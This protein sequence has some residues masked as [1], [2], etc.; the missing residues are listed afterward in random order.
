MAFDKLLRGGRGGRRF[1]ESGGGIAIHMRFAARCG[2][3][4]VFL[5]SGVFRPGFLGVLGFA[6][7]TIAAN[8]GFELGVGDFLAVETAQPDGYV[9]VD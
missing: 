4:G 2:M 9:F 6:R 3:R 5:E 7:A 8:G 1:H